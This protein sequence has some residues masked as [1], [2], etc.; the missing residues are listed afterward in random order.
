MWTVNI[1][2]ERT[3]DRF[4]PG[5]L[6]VIAD[7]SIDYHIDNVPTHNEGGS[8]DVLCS[9]GIEYSSLTVQDAWGQTAPDFTWR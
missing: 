7:Y 3:G 9:R 2:L 6:N 5:F 4:A 8:L 1:H